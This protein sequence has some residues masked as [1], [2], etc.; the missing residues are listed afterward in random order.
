MTRTIR[1]RFAPPSSPSARRTFWLVM[2]A[3]RG[4]DQDPGTGD[5]A[6]IKNRTTAVIRAVVT[7]WCDDGEIGCTVAPSTRSF[8]V[9]S[10]DVQHVGYH[11]ISHV[12]A[13]AQALGLI[14]GEQREDFLSADHTVEFV[15]VGKCAADIHRLWQEA[16]LEE[17]GAAP[18]IPQF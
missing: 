5:D 3:L 6:A 12:M 18:Q 7:S 15:M 9:R 8:E 14:T 4:P 16:D 10:T 11:F 13:A 1:N 2:T 17:F